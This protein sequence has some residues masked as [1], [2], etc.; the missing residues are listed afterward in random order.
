MSKL[1]QRA[2]RGSAGCHDET[3][4][5]PPRELQLLESGRV[6]A[7]QASAHY[8]CAYARALHEGQVESISQILTEQRNDEW[9]RLW[10]T[11]AAKL[12]PLE[13]ARDAEIAKVMVAARKRCAAK[14]TAKY[15]ST[16][17]RSILSVAT[18]NATW[19]VATQ[20]PLM[21]SSSARS[22]QRPRFTTQRTKGDKCRSAPG[23]WPTLRRPPSPPPSLAATLPR[24]HRRHRRPR[25]R[26]V[27]LRHHPLHR[28]HLLRLR[29]CHLH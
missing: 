17:H 24:R 11:A 29:L 21:R 16:L 20:N 1:L 12:V 25:H 19:T 14:I 13:A 9:E 3:D 4:D 8:A 5:Q 22:P 18:C 7:A 6:A 2:Q 15:E 10:A 23:V 26:H 27:H 28:R